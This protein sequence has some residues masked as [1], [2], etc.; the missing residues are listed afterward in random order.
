MSDIPSRTKA[1]HG[2]VMPGRRKFLVTGLGVAAASLLS[3]AVA[4][5]LT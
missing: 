3:L 1:D 2:P 4:G 5:H